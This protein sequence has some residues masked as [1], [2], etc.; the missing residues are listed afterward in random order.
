MSD[1]VLDDL[2]QND[3]DALMRCLEQ[4]PR[5]QPGGTAK[6]WRE[7][8]ERACFRV[9]CESLQ[10]RPWQLP[11]F[12]AD[13]DDPNERDKAAQALLRKTLAA[14]ISRYEPDPLAALNKKKR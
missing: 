13:E 7:S 11:P 4:Y 6:Q 14:G 2:D 5:P 10:L 12:V 8:A 9:Q 1:E 3:F